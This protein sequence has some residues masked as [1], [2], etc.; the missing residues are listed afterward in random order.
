M[1]E[2]EMWR[3]RSF[4][5]V[6]AELHFG[7][8]AERLNMTQPTLS[9]QIQALE[10]QLGVPLLIRGPHG[11][12]LTDA[13]RELRDEGER[14]LEQSLRVVERARRAGRG[15]MGQVSI[16]FVGSALDLVVELLTGMRTQHPD[17]A[18][19]LAE[20]PFRDPM[21]GLLS[22]EDDLVF[23]RDVIA[24][25]E[26]DL[27]RLSQD[28]SCLVVPVGHPLAGE[29]EVDRNQIEA[30]SD[31]VF[32]S[33]SRWMNLL[34][35]QPRKLDEIASPSATLRLIEAGLGVSVM[36]AGFKSQAGA[37]VRFIPV[38]ELTSTLQ[39]ALPRRRATSA[40]AALL[41][42][43]TEL[44]PRVKLDLSKTAA[45]HH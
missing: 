6:A 3:L 14:L 32:L 15:D 18:F 20:R 42:L 45:L 30:L 22:G 16:G 29:Q 37:G 1:A 21:S 25:H 35:F 5:V 9:R 43:L 12:A 17:V 24:D 41:E 23:A 38:S 40:T 13:G 26:W 4:V 19:V 39:L 28:Q 44:I 7:R 11:V 8:A 2:L 31:Q 36:P 33:T 10:S 34:G 27:V